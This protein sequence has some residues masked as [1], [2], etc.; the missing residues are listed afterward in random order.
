[1]PKGKSLTPQEREEIL[2]LSEQERWP[3][4]E[5]AETLGVSRQTAYDHGVR[6][7]GKEWNKVARWAAKNHE[8]LFEE[9]KR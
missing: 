3:T 9:L 2:R 8:R 4:Q 1:M 6:G 5:I 7:P